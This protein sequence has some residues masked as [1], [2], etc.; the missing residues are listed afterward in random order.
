MDQTWC[1]GPT[2][3]WGTHDLVGGAISILKNMSIVSQ[4]EG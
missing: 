2:E 4:W 3:S 1:H